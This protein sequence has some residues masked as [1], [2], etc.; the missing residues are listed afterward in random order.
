MPIARTVLLL[1]LA[2]VKAEES[3]VAPRPNFLFML[4]D[5]WVR[6]NQLSAVPLI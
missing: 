6:F 2:S 1:A 3:I 5:D 4:A